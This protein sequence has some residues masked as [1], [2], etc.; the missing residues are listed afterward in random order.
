MKGAMEIILKSEEARISRAVKAVI[1]KSY[2]I[3]YSG[4]N[5]MR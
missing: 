5:L 4:M 2:K 1:E 3:K